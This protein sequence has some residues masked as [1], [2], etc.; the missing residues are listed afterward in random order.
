MFE[1]K[2][3]KVMDIHYTRIIMSYIRMGG[4]LSKRSGR[5]VFNQW[6]VTLG[7]DDEDITNI[8][9]I[10]TNGKM[11]LESKAYKF[12]QEVYTNVDSY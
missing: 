12:L 11:E 1:N 2:K 10:A 7:L 5:S 4:V 3:D 8:L 9:E 6:L